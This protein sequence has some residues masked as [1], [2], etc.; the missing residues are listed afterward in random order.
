MGLDHKSI[1]LMNT[2]DLH[3]NAL[4]EFKATLKCPRYKNTIL[5]DIYCDKTGVI[6]HIEGNHTE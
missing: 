6:Y 5:C 1:L 2:R 4:I 3:R